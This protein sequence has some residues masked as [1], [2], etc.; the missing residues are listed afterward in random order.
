MSVNYAEGLSAYEHK[1]KCGMPEK[2]DA[3]EVVMRKSIELAE[4]IQHSRHVVVHTGAGISTAAG[5][6]DFRGPK[7]VWTLEQKGEKPQVNVTFDQAIPTKTHMAL[8]ELERAGLVHYVISQN[9]DGLHVRSGFPR[10]RL[11]ELHGNMFVEE[12]DKCNKQYVQEC[13]VPT[14]GLRPTGNQ[15]TQKKSRGRCRGKLRDT[16]LDW[17]DALPAQD[18]ELGDQHSRS[19]DLSLCLGTSLQIVPSGNL[20]VLTKKN[21]GKIAIVNLQATKHD[22]KA[23]LRIHGY[24]DEVMSTVMQ[25]LGLQIPKYEGPQVVMTSSHVTKEE[26]KMDTVAKEETKINSVTTSQNPIKSQ[27]LQ[28]EEIK[29]ETKFAINHESCQR[30]MKDEFESMCDMV[31]KQD[32]CKHD[33]GIQIH[34]NKTETDAS[35]IED[36]GRNNSSMEEHIAECS[37]TETPSDGPAETNLNCAQEQCQVDTNT[38]QLT[39]Q[40]VSRA[41]EEVEELNISANSTAVSTESQQ[42]DHISCESHFESIESISGSDTQDL[43]QTE[44]MMGND[45]NGPCTK[46]LKLDEGVLPGQ[47]D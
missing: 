26:T 11:S 44:G 29:H 9:I 41:E 1:G 19:A 34:D 39:S 21:G 43:Q 46:K 20:P 38:T 23:D 35:R 40:S 30:I 31:I 33:G 14:L 24:V 8:V 18:L 7:G 16:I 47:G 13:A 36:Q 6:P 37:D 42:G 12:C 32:Q 15:C 45:E 3:S 5:I 2:Y 17:E 25:H 22:K 4:M 28:K 27:V 10:D